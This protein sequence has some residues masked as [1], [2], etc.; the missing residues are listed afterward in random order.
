MI[1]VSK[2]GE[3]LLDLK[4]D[5]KLLLEKLAQSFSRHA[6]GCI[7]V[8]SSA[9]LEDE[10]DVVYKLSHCAVNLVLQFGLHSFQ[11]HGIRNHAAVSG[12]CCE[13]IVSKHASLVLFIQTQQQ[14]LTAHD[15][16]RYRSVESFFQ[17]NR[18][19]Y[20]LVTLPHTKSANPFITVCA[21][22]YR[23]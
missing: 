11:P 22:V 3:S 23:R 5:E 20:S 10:S 12:H 1:E 7:P 8:E 17:T 6:D 19:P 4:A 13:G 18:D 15:V 2:A 9:V 16:L 14:I 21:V